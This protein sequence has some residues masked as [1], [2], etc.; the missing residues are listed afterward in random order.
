VEHLLKFLTISKFIS[1]FNLNR[2]GVGCGLSRMEKQ[3]D[4]DVT[5]GR[6]HASGPG[7]MG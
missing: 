1:K 3:A 5:L 6:V 2:F 7:N 4:C